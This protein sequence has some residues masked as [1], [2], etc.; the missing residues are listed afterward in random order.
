ME[1]NIV[2]LLSLLLRWIGPEIHT[3]QLGMFPPK[4]PKNVTFPTIEI[5]HF[6]QR[7]V[8]TFPT[9][10]KATERPIK[11]QNK[12]REEGVKERQKKETKYIH[13]SSFIAISIFETAYTRLKSNGS[14][15]AQGPAAD[16][17]QV[18]ILVRGG[19]EYFFFRVSNG[20]QTL[21]ARGFENY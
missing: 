21:E 12:M 16:W 9:W 1:T 11:P 20:S 7:L 3:K 19:G 15:I 17:F 10:T 18:W 6:P 2:P 4:S 8:E 5:V 14:C 13:S